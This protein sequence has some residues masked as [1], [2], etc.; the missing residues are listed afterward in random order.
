MTEPE[1]DERP[2]VDE[3]VEEKRDEKAHDEKDEKTWDEK[4][5][6]DMLGTATFAAILIWIGVVL[7]GRNLGWADQYAWWR[8]WAV[9]MTGVG[10]ILLLEAFARTLSPAGRRSVGG[11]LIVGLVFVGVGLQALFEVTFVWPVLLIGAGLWILLQG[12]GR[13]RRRRF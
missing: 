5:G 1:R 3:K 6:R 4:W 9:V 10:V 8:T 11:N 12:A 13:R 7:L 2:V